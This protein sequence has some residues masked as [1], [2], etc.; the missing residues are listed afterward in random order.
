MLGTKVSHY[1][2]ENE[3]GRGGMGVVYGAH[4][5]QLQRKVALKLLSGEIAEHSERWKRILAEARMAAG[6]NHPGITTVYEVGR[7]GEQI[8]IVMELDRKST[9]LNSSHS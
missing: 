1:R 5:E 4:D 3:L 6:L 2:I 8:F 7:D 9:R